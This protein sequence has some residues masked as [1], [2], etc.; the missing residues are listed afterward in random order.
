MR[1]KS[2]LGIGAAGIAAAFL[3]AGSA[4][5]FV[6]D[7][8]T[9]AQKHRRDVGKQLSKYIF[10]LSKTGIKCEK[11]GAHTGSECDLTDGSTDAT[12]D[13]KAAGKFFETEVED[14][15]MLKV[16]FVR[17][18]ARKLLPA[19]THVLLIK[20]GRIFAQ[21]KKEK[22]LTDAV[23]SDALDC[24]LTVQENGGRYWLTSCRPR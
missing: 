9:D 14:P 17:P 12:V 18:E 21:G 16:C 11:K 1:R 20:H 10:C 8:K 22:V 23:L 15:F 13:P 4:Q 6:I 5:G 19:I 24:R 2:W 3:L 7:A